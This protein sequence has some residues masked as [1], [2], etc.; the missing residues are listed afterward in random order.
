MKEKLVKVIWLQAAGC[1]GCTVS[2]LNSSSLKIKNVLLD[3]IVPGKC[4][5]LVFQPTIM[6]GA[7]EKVME[8]IKGE[9]EKKDFYL[10][11]EGAIP[12]KDG[13]VYGKIGEKTFLELFLSL[14]RTSLGII[15]LG[16]C[17]AFGG[18]PAG[19]PNP[20]GCESLM[21]IMAEHNIEKLLINIPG[22]PPH[23][24]WFLGTLAKIIVGLPLELD[25]LNRPKDFYGK[26]IHENCPRRPYF[27]E[28]KFASSFTEEGCLYLLGCKGPFAYADCPLRQWNGGTNWFIKNGAP[29]LGCVE[30]D[31]PDGNSPFFEK[32]SRQEKIE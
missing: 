28:G 7:G 32:L 8:V 4:V 26:L 31:F 14:A 2:L 20:T 1:S 6:A 25:E 17:S 11:V 5:S 13:G 3:E 27:D 9:E 29:C 15:A 10:V 18:I 30:P 23:P 19:N 16:S 24:D 12:T 21:K 22:C